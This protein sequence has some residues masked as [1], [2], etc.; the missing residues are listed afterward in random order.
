M[1]DLLEPSRTYGPTDAA[2]DTPIN[3]GTGEKITG[4]SA[5]DQRR[6]GTSQWA[7]T[8][9]A[10]P[11]C[12]ETVVL[13]AGTHLVGRTS[14]ALLT[15]VH[16]A[17][18]LL[19]MHHARLRLPGG[20][21]VDHAG[22]STE[23]L[24]GGVQPAVVSHRGDTMV[25]IGGGLL[26]IAELPDGTAEPLTLPVPL[27]VAEG[28]PPTAVVA[29]CRSL[30]RTPRPPRPATPRPLHVVGPDAPPV[31]HTAGL[32][33]AMLALAA[34]GAVAVLLHQPMF[35][36]FGAMG[37]TVAVGSWLAQ[38]IA[39]HRR[40]GRSRRARQRELD[41]FA[42]A[43]EDHHRALLAGH[44]YRAMTIE[45]ATHALL[46][47]TDEI[48]Q[49]R[50]EHDD[51]G[52]VSL[53]IG[54]LTLEA[55]LDGATDAGDLSVVA[56]FDHEAMT[57]DL[58]PGCRLAVH[59]E[60]DEAHA[61]VRSLL[62][63][64]M[65]A[66]GP[67]DLRIAIVT[68]QPARWRWITASPHLATPAGAAVLSP[69]ATSA[70]LA[71]FER[72]TTGRLVVVTDHPAELASRTTMTRRLVH[73]DDALIAV[74]DRGDK[75][76]QVC[77]SVVHLG[78]R[79]Q[80]RWMPTTTASLATPLHA[81]GIS[82]R[83]A[84]DLVARLARL[85]DPDDPN[86]A[87]RRLPNRV[88]LAS[89]L[90]GRG[91]DPACPATIAAG[92]V[93]GGADPRP[94]APV[95]V[96]IDGVLDV[97][98]VADGPH[99]L[100]AGTTGAGK[101]ELL[102][103]L[104]VGLAANSSPEHLSLV[105]IDYKGGAA[106]DVCAGLPHV[107]AVVTDLDDH[108]A[109]RALRSLR[110]ELTRRE[111]ILRRHGAADLGELRAVTGVA[112][113][114]RL[115]VVI[116]EFAALAA[117]H[118]HFLSSLV[119]VAQRGRSLGVHL[120]L[121]TQRP[122]GVLSD[123]IRANT[124]LRIALRLLDRDD[125]IDVVGDAS[126]TTFA[127]GLPGRAMVR[128]GEGE[129][130]VVHVASMS[131]DVEVVTSIG[132]AAALLGLP[133]AA[134]PWQ[135][136]I[137]AVLDEVPPGVLGLVDDPDHQRVE[138]LGWER[139]RGPLL[140]VGRRG[141]GTTSALH[142]V[143]SDVLDRSWREVN[144]GADPISVTVID[145]LGDPSLADL[146]A[147]PHCAGV[148]AVRDTEL[149]RR[150]I[151]RAAATTRSHDPAAVDHWGG[152]LLAIDG[153]DV[154]RR[155]L[156]GIE[157]DDLR[158]MLDD[159]VLHGT[160]RGVQVV[161]TTAHPATLP[162]ALMA[163]C[164]EVWVGAVHDVHDAATT[165]LTSTDVLTGDAHPPGRMVLAR[166]RLVAQVRAPR[167]ATLPTQSPEGAT[168]PHRVPRLAHLPRVVTTGDLERRRHG[169]GG[170]RLIIGQSFEPAEPDDCAAWL[171]LGDGA[172][173]ALI[174]G[175]PRS[176]RSTALATV[177]SQWQAA[178]PTGR[179][180][181]VRPQRDDPAVL[182]GLL[183]EWHTAWFA[184]PAEPTLLAVDDA[185]LVDD[186]TGALAALIARRLAHL[187][188]VAAGTP[189][190]LRRL[191]GHWSTGL[192]MPRRGLLAAS[193]LD[194]DGDLL[195]VTLPRHC[196]IT[197]RPGLMYAVDNGVITLCQVAIG[198]AAPAADDLGVAP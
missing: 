10:G 85:I 7:V 57:V 121:A 102:R 153:L 18:G 186:P 36:L 66:V 137:P 165:G 76:A 89:L 155:A 166:R 25:E 87:A 114:P 23:A 31:R 39:E 54:T 109:G 128:F 71:E 125:A 69:S 189:D 115:V 98:L 143:V 196:P 160:G 64:A 79:M 159:I 49:R 30:V 152:S 105:L 16:A 3:T 9:V 162:A 193:C 130:H 88:G 111:A 107:A 198:D 13:A 145:A 97:D 73:D 135:P 93:A 104:I 110:A 35:L 182:S 5:D 34:A 134:A 180:H 183:N 122:H 191:Y 43:L 70:E 60:L 4:G 95:A 120:I 100:I 26:A 92:W 45:R 139:H 132:L 41:G 44:R 117:E 82:Q 83:R 147:H 86:G 184:A 140:I 113:V 192:R 188:V 68:E 59:G 47:T 51:L 32:L 195:G 133:T 72:P 172:A 181:T 101:S 21:A 116:D 96:G 27:P 65:I 167:P 138:H 131:T 168:T 19:E 75:I 185:E 6:T 146:A 91:I 129:R 179:A 141:S 123:D 126:P 187:A 163:S 197:P 8:W 24:A 2:T 46:A 94:T 29:A 81:A 144:H 67:A 136:P 148:V 48:W 53:G 171:V 158:T 149:V 142:C 156:D 63:Q 20:S 176:G 161:A 118:P 151:T 124:N 38:R 173:H 40:A 177:V 170:S 175:P 11:D 74:F 178:H 127:R 61:V 28:D 15:P 56:D 169:A 164:A 150:A 52:V 1:T 90:A 108:L 17:D 58:G 194:A 55:Q 190:A 84:A 174:L 77:T 112:T 157:H 80:A 154:V 22:V 78:R 106:F 62:C 33:P 12:G 119:D 103:S 42:A 50:A 37:A 14:R 99:A